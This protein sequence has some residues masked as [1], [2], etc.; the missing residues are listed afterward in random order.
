MN[1]V[2]LVVHGLSAISVYSDVVFTRLV[3][4]ASGVVAL[5]VAL[6]G[7]AVAVRLFTTLAVPGWATYVVGFLLVILLQAV[8]FVVALTFQILG[9]RQ[10]LTVVPQRDVLSYVGLVRD[11]DIQPSKTS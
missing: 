5:S 8:M 11:V 6:L 9:A 7:A 4:A 10:Q 3:V 1:F 2:A